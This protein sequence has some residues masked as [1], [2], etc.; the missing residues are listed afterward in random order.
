MAA[1]NRA[2]FGIYPDRPAV[3][4]AITQFLRAGFR[5]AD[6][7]ALF[8][9]NPGSK[10][11]GHEKSTKL[12]EGATVGGFAG[13]IV[14][15]ILGWLIAEGWLT[16]PALSSL[17]AAG[18]I[19]AILAGG[20]ALGAVGGFIGA[21]IGLAIP[22]YEAIRFAGRIREGG[23]LVSVHCDNGHW[24]NR[25]KAI[26]DDSGA[27]DV[28]V[29]REKEGDFGNFDKPM[30]RVR[31]LTQETHDEVVTRDEPQPGAQTVRVRS[32]TEQHEVITPDEPQPATQGDKP[33]RSLSS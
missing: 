23:V 33:Y 4:E 28:A 25:A 3:E 12:P 1:K 29:C 22:E 9:E 8:P 2:A 6:L 20:G 16:I 18:P 5:K 14:G 30:P 24:V 32:H 15:G 31:T 10:D 13:G 17:V 27:Q 26:L 19:L 21:L 11:F 7:S